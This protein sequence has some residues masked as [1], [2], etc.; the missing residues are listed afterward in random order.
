MSSAYTY[1]IIERKC[2]L[3]LSSHL[4]LICDAA[5]VTVAGVG[6][7]PALAWRGGRAGAGAR[8]QLARKKILSCYSGPGAGL[9]PAGS[10]WQMSSRCPAAECQSDVPVPAK[11][12]LLS[13]GPGPSLYPGPSE[14]PLWP[15]RAL[16]R[17]SVV[18]V[19]TV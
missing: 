4:N 9:P 18:L 19:A 10:Q 7:S 17:Y 11:L 5:R 8:P 14:G 2:N 13:W 15:R 6:P 12:V 3:N 16:A 1:A